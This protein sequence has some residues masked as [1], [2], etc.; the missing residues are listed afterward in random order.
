M[1]RAK[2][3]PQ[4]THLEWVA[5]HNTTLTLLKEVQEEN[6]SLKERI[7]ILENKKLE[8]KEATENFLRRRRK[9]FL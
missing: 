6:A 8:V 5:I 7:A 4:L 9:R 1:V 2:K 3:N